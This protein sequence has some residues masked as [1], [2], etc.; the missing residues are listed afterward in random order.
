MLARAAVAWWFTVLLFLIVGWVINLYVRYSLF[1]LPI[2]ALGSGVLLSATWPLGRA[3]R[4]LAVFMLIF[5]AVEPL[6]LW[7]YRIT[8]AFK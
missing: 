2:I 5:F 3:G 6:A 8:Y 7:Q 4:W 1:A